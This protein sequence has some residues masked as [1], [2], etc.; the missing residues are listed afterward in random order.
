MY[1]FFCLSH[2]LKKCKDY[3]AR[4][5][6]VLS[7]QPF[8]FFCSFIYLFIFYFQPEEVEEAA[9]Q[10]NLFGRKLFAGV[11][12]TFEIDMGGGAK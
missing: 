11:L 2:G 8:V 7:R 1:D 10:Q 3:S 5:G 12:N 4:V 6:R 9:R